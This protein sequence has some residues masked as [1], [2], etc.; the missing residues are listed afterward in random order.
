[1]KLLLK[2]DLT[3]C[4]TFQGLKAL[5]AIMRNIKDAPPDS[6]VCDRNCNECKML[7]IQRRL[8]MCHYRC[9]VLD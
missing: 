4:L 2:C 9:M 8:E 7:P 5:R 6:V 1:M 3:L